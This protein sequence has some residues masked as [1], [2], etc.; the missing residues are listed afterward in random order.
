M[1]RIVDL[2][3][4]KRWISV[5]LGTIALGI[6]FSGLSPAFFKLS[7]LQNILVQSSVTGIMAIGM[8]FII[9]S[10][11]IDISVG[12]ILFFSSAVLAKSISIT[13][14][15]LI[16]ISA[17]IV[18]AILLGLT[19]GILVMS[20]NINPLVSTL[21][22]YTIYRGMSIHLTKAQSI[23]TPDSVRF[24]GNGDLWGI[25]IPIIL[26]VLVFMIAAYVLTHTRYG[27][28]VLAIGNSERSAIESAIPVIPVI[29]AT[30]AIGGLA[31]GVSGLILLGRVG[32]LQS[33]MGIGIEF[34]VI[35]AVVLGGTK[36][37]GG[38]GSLL[39][40]VIGSVFLT[41]II[42]GLNLINASPFMYD[43]VKGIVLII[44]VALDKLSALRQEKYLLELKARRILASS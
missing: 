23:L 18:T 20:F 31:S 36:L 15:P 14:N 22:T 9:M 26:L 8:T 25:P 10:S 2:I 35:T 21:A 27:T 11:G 13:G 7:N 41:L 32:G 1:Q 29:L 43:A 42:N 3:K 6:I 17:A 16:S 28:Y 33:E 12:A 40:S 19:N 5:L 38:S 30:Y 4:Q 44:A 34:T 39:G 24:F 37:S